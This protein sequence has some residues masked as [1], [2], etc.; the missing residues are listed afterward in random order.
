MIAPGLSLPP[1]SEK[2][3]MWSLCRCVATTAYSLPPHA[4]LMSRAIAFMFA[5][6]PTVPKS[7][8]MC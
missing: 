2:P 7:I 8:R 3:L 4:S 5:F 1:A 6:P